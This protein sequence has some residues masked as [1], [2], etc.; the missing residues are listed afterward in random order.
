V[1]TSTLDDCQWQIRSLVVSVFAAWVEVSRYR[2]ELC[3]APVA[4]RSVA[5][6]TE[7]DVCE[8]SGVRLGRSSETSVVRVSR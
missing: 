1:F 8:T 5:F 3:V 7:L 6:L 4:E 2:A